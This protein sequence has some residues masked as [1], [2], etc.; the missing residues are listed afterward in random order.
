LIT[1]DPNKLLSSIAPRSKI[2]RLTAKGRLSLKKTA[3]S[4]IDAIDFINRD[5]VSRVALETIKDYQKRAKGDPKLRKEL[6]RNPKQLIQRVQNAVVAQ[7]STE[8]KNKYQGEKYEW[9]PSSANEP[10]PEHQLKYGKIFTVGVGEM[11]GDR[12]GCK[13]GMRILTS[14]ETLKL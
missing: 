12:Y 9:L 4:F 13:C 3:L 1:Y 7:V 6:L 11:P 10:D 8:I 14:E 2:K 5:E